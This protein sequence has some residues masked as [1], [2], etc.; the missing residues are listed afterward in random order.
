MR[1]V[2]LMSMLEDVE[3]FMA[4]R[5]VS[6]APALL[7]TKTWTWLMRSSFMP[8]RATL[9]SWPGPM[10]R[11]ICPVGPSHAGSGLCGMAFF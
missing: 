10:L 7:K 3:L 2:M 4:K 6:S 1:E 8:E 9:V 11:W 5:S